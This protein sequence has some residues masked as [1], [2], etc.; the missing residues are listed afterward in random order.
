MVKWVVRI[1][2]GLLAVLVVA[3]VALFIA[4]SVWMGGFKRELVAGSEIAATKL[5]DIEY[6]AVG[7]GPV[8]LNIHG[9]PGGYDVSIAGARARPQ[10]FSGRKIISVSRPGYLRTPLASGRSPAEQADLY[11]ALL[12]ELKI[13]RVIVSGVS[14]GGPSALAFAMRHPERTRGLILIVP[15]LTRDRGDPDAGIPSGLAVVIQ[16]F[17]V[18]VG[19]LAMQWAAPMAAPEIDPADK[20]QIARM[21]EMMPAFLLADQRGPGRANDQAEYLKLDI[22]A[23]PLEQMSVP[24]FIAHGDVDEN[25]SYAGSAAVA[26]RIPGA[27][28]MT[29]KGGDHLVFVSRGKEIDKAISAFI[30]TLPP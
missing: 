20:L 29:L 28:L 3:T 1:V 13:D 8:T 12:D 21:R 11:A 2:G 26:A 30:A 19:S 18:W 24:T 14:G 27:E 7:A 15:H 9:S 25:A 23:W 16:D 6:A 5:G 22:E 17:A 10:D 4:F